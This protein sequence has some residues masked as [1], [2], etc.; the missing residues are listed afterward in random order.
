M[1]RTIS[2][3]LALMAHLSFAQEVKPKTV[4][5]E[6]PIQKGTSYR[7]DSTAV[8]AK[9]PLKNIE[10]PQVYHVLPK[11]L[12]KDQVSTGFT[13][14]LQNVTGVS[15][16]RTQTG[17]PG[18]GASVYALR[19][20]AV[21]PTLVNGMPYLNNAFIETYNIESVEVLKG[22]SST[23]FGSSMSAHGGLI[24]IT[25]KKPEAQNI[26]EIGALFGANQLN[27]YTLDV[28]RKINGRVAAR[29]VAAYHTEN[30]F[31]DAGFN[32]YVFVAPSV[33]VL[34]NDR[35]S[36]SANA[37]IRSATAANA[38][39]LFLS[40]FTPS[41]FNTGLFEKNYLRSFT[42]NPLI[43]KTP[44]INFQAQGDY[45]ID[46][47]WTSQTKLSFSNTKT[48][49]YAQFLWN[50]ASGT[51]L[52]RYISKAHGNTTTFDLQQNFSRTIKVYKFMNR[53]VAGVDIF[54]TSISNHGTP[55]ITNGAVNFQ[56][57][58]DTG[59]L[60]TEDYDAMLNGLPRS[61]AKGQITSTAVYVNDVI[62]FLPNLKATVSFRLDHL[63]T[64]SDENNQATGS[65]TVFSPKL[66]VVYQPMKEKVYVFANFMNGMSALTPY[67][68]ARMDGSTPRVS[69]Y[70]PERATQVELGTK[71]HLYQNKV[72]LM[73]SYYYSK[74]SQKTLMDPNN[75]N[76]F[77]QGAKVNSSGIELSVISNPIEGLELIAGYSHNIAEITKDVQNGAYLGLRPEEAGPKNLLNFWAKYQPKYSFLKGFTVGLGGNYAGEHRA[78]NRTTGHFTLPA[79]LLLN[80]VIS[81]S[82]KKYSVNLKLENITNQKYY[83]GW[84]SIAPQ[85]PRTV[86]L[87]FV[88]G[89]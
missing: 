6:L 80:S 12:I 48:D 17:L 88:F 73:A 50:M 8:V 46:E 65:H 63:Q 75:P 64:K 77:L 9:Y 23:L 81:Y 62:D 34:V 42:A 83:T 29:L 76:Q 38:P 87:G 54:N 51:N 10:N 18:N 45:K 60:F 5:Q 41:S 21:Q 43:L 70:N 3:V 82:A 67:S 25:T 56:N 44:S 72:A 13:S 86:A 84:G 71:A 31:Q 69:I 19:G 59:I 35:L 16:L 15:L 27:R 2:C 14:V 36:V 40:R 52:T 33:K 61:N 55:W 30:S 89:L 79:Y 37:E 28:N 1:K 22:N 47:N 26:T 20:F 49:G 58:N 7:I 4:P 39:Q 78:L 24:N 74:L 32:R 11:K 57:G 68:T 66:G 85:N 53:L